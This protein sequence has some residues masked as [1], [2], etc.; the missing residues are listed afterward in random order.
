MSRRLTSE[1][2]ATYRDDGWLAPLDLLSPTEVAEARA[3]LERYEATT[4]GP[5]GGAE[6]TGGHMLFTWVDE[7]MRNDDLLDAVEDLIGPDILCW[8]SIFWVKEAQSPTYVS[9]HQDLNY[10][11]LDNDELVNVWVALS[12]A[13]LESGCMQVL[14]GSHHEAL[15]HDETYAAD[16]MLT[17][18]QELQ[19]DVGD[20]EVA[21]MALTPGQMSMHNVLLAHGS[22][23]NTTND[24]R[25]GLSLQYMPTHTKQRLVEWDS[26]ALVR[27]TDR[28][29]HFE[30]APRPQHDF[31]PAAVAFHARAAESLRE[32]LYQGAT[33]P[34]ERAP[35]L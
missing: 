13:S 32:L 29:G 12:P 1:Q 15:D 17:R 26:A 33:P 35:T 4:G 9:W 3:A 31:D 27:G 22:G 7:L 6:R 2:V 18:G 20:R 30:H 8:N 16:N 10:W 28:F 25:I 21:T 24:R 19:I 14:P 5:I 11:G 34:E 23:P